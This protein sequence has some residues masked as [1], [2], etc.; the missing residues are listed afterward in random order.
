[1]G[2]CRCDG[3]DITVSPMSAHSHQVS[4]EPQGLLHVRAVCGSTSLHNVRVYNVQHMVL[5]ILCLLSAG[6]LFL[7]DNERNCA[8]ETWS[9]WGK[10]PARSPCP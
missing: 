4:P 9:S 6:A 8:D 2:E 3:N 5:P 10:K 1:M 7:P